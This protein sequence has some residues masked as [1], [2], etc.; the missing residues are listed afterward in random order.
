[1][2]VSI[3]NTYDKESTTH[4]IERRLVDGF[5]A[6]L[7]ALLPP[8]AGRVLEVGCGEGNQLRKLTDALPDAA[9]VGLDL[10]PPDRSE[11]RAQSA[12]MVCGSVLALPYADRSF[13]LVLALEMLEHVDDPGAALAEI[14]RVTAGTVLLSV[15]WEP[16]WRVGN[17][18][19]GRYLGQFGNTPGHIQHFTRRG[20]LRL[21]GRYFR[22]DEVR[23]PLPWTMVRARAW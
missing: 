9:L 10:A 8:G 23:R 7:M 21:V 18:V 6:D 19:R 13:D 17:L 14:A 5:D 11:W 20:F 16:V 12:E 3:G 22:V 2:S 1:V 4:P 15:P